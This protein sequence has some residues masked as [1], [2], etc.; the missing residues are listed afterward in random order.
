MAGQGPH[1]TSFSGQAQMRSDN[2]QDQGENQN[3]LQE[4]GTHALNM[5]QGAADVGK[6]AVLGAAS[7]ACGVATG[8]ANVASGAADVVRNTFAGAPDAHNASLDNANNPSANQSTYS[9]RPGYA[10]HPN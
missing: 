4:T 3:F 5:A 9:N 2:V 6:G 1:N 8:A 7:L 10:H